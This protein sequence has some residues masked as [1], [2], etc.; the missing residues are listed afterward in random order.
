MSKQQTTQGSPSQAASMAAPSP[1]GEYYFPVW[2][3]E[4]TVTE[5]MVGLRGASWTTQ[6]L[7]IGCQKLQWTFSLDSRYTSANIK[8]FATKLTGPRAS[9]MGRM[10]GRFPH[11]VHT[12]RIKGLETSEDCVLRV[13]PHSL[14]LGDIVERCFHTSKSFPKN[15]ENLLMVSI[16]HITGP[17]TRA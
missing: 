16:I 1:R 13:M 5:R 12:L 14:P 4:H 15:M 8:V 2:L 17:T 10:E 9:K 7:E 6:L 3:K 11:S